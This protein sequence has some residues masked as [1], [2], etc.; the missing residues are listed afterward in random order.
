MSFLHSRI[1]KSHSI[2]VRARYKAINQAFLSS[3][4]T[5]LENYTAAVRV[6]LGERLT[7]T[8]LPMHT[9]A[10]RGARFVAEVPHRRVPT[11][12]LAVEHRCRLQMG[13]NLEVFV[14]LD[15]ADGAT[16]DVEIVGAGGCGGFHLAR[17]PTV[18]GRDQIRAVRRGRSVTVVRVVI[19][20]FCN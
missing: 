4:N 11:A 20:D 17:E 7:V 12:L 19:G 1:T 10:H 5:I 15:P 13:R 6:Q 9:N 14:A 16:G 8:S 18:V 3:C 2:Q